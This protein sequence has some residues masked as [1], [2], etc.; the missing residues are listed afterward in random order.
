MTKDFH[1]SRR[2]ILEPNRMKECIFLNTKK[3]FLLLYLSFL[4][5]HIAVN[6][7]ADSYKIFWPLALFYP[8]CSLHPT[9]AEACESGICGI[10][11][12]GVIEGSRKYRLLY[13]PSFS[14]FLSHLSL[15]ERKMDELLWRRKRQF[16]LALSLLN[17]MTFRLFQKLLLCLLYIKHKYFFLLFPKI[18]TLSLM[19]K[20]FSSLSSH[21]M[22]YQHLMIKWSLP[23]STAH[24]LSCSTIRW[25]LS[26]DEHAM[27][28]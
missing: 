11:A 9:S 24:Q 18:V 12:V 8:L 15:S 26:M 16:V 13:F 27:C 10:L 20:T 3:K 7:T 5:Y 21:E 14:P 19:L 2:P 4:F 1:K 6:S 22:I 23:F 25:L 28:F 17:K